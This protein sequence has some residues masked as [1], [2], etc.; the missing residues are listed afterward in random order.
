MKLSRNLVIS[1]VLLIVLA[2]IISNG[3]LGI[4]WEQIRSRLNLPKIASTN[5]PQTANEK[6]KIGNEESTVIDIVDNVSPSVVT[7]SISTARSTGRL[8]QIDPND[9]F[10]MFRQQ[11]GGAT[12]QKVEQDIGSGFI[13]AAATICALATSWVNYSYERLNTLAD[14]FK[15]S[16]NKQVK[17]S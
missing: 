11:P 12:P 16:T 15:P 2:V 7:V 5:L 6:V 14:R 8:F 1:L 9:P 10:N 4:D 3:A 13:V 17:N